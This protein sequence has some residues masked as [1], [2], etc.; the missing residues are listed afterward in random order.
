VV[1]VGGVRLT[2]HARPPPARPA[3]PVDHPAATRTPSAAKAPANASVRAPPRAVSAAAAGDP[4]VVCGLGTV[5]LGADGADGAQG[6]QGADAALGLWGFLARATQGTGERWLLALENSGDN[7]ARATGLYLEGKIATDDLTLQL[8]TD[9]TRDA[10][11]QLAVGSDDPAVYTIAGYACGT[12]HN[13]SGGACPQI[14]PSGWARR[15]PDNAAAWLALASQA[16]AQHDSAAESSAFAQAAKAQRVEDYSDSLFDFAEPA[17]PVDA[18]PLERWYFATEVIGIG[19]A[20]TPPRGVLSTY[21]GAVSI[22]D[23][24]PR[25]QCN[26]LAELLVTK[27]TTLLDL[28]SGIGLARRLGWPATRVAELEQQSRLA[29]N[30]L[31]EAVP[32]D[33]RDLWDCGSVQRGNAF[34]R[35]RS[36]WGEL[37]AARELK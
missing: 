18:T 24:T 8:T 12:F 22:A 37:G 17:L 28:G 36:Q 32:T 29:L 26:A 4:V 31:K 13:A 27:G 1:V 25:E 6:A 9:V 33:I 34:V 35:L 10:L 16:S 11:V 3:P 14:T 23:G 2:M 30:T 19:V 20:S 5:A 15:D 21:C 7:R